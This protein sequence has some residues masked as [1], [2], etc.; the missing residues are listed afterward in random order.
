MKIKFNVNS[1]EFMN[2]LYNEGKINSGCTVQNNFIIL[3]NDKG[4]VTASLGVCNGK[5][6]TMDIA[7]DNLMVKEQNTSKLEFDVAKTLIELEEKD[8]K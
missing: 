4:D 1:Q 7:G 5:I 2:R 3:R 6:I 8:K